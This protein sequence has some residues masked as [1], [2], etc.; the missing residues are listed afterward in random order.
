MHI[1]DTKT[2][3]LQLSANTSEAILLYV[4]LQFILFHCSKYFVFSS[5]CFL[6]FFSRGQYHSSTLFKSCAFLNR[7]HACSGCMET[8]QCW[9]WLRKN[10]ACAKKSRHDRNQRK[11][12]ANKTACLSCQVGKKAQEPRNTVLLH[13]PSNKLFSG[14]LQYDMSMGIIYLPYIPEDCTVKVP[15]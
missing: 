10:V 5:N 15:F 12:F 8:I 11:D 2:E 7:W 13:I 1:I 9:K 3:K 6:I 4:V 14:I